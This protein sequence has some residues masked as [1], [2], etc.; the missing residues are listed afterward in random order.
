MSNQLEAT[1]T[2]TEYAVELR[3]EDVEREA[4]IQAARLTT[5]NEQETNASRV[6]HE[7]FI[8][9]EIEHEQKLFHLFSDSPY[10]ATIRAERCYAIK[11]AFELLSAIPRQLKLRVCSKTLLLIFYTCLFLYPLITF[12]VN[13]NYVLYNLVCI[14]IGGIGFGL[15]IYEF[16]QLFKDLK[17]IRMVY[18]QNAYLWLLY[19]GR[20]QQQ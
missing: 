9:T 7:G 1:A 13:R 12:L 15:Q 17:E 6:K 11:K 5:H 18:L 4:G 2:S 20:L 8:L 19:T 3:D 16:D 10:N 14:A